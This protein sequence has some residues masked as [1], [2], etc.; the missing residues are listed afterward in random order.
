VKKKLGS[1]VH[2]CGCCHAVSRNYQ[3]I[4]TALSNQSLTTIFFSRGCAMGK[5]E[6]WRLLGHSGI[7]KELQK[8]AL[9]QPL[10]LDPKSFC[11]KSLASLNL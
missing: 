1:D 7:L 5:E 10:S 9:T 11:K 8:L 2:L 3:L 4:T 6:S